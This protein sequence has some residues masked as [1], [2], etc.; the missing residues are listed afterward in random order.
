MT[1]LIRVTANKSNTTSLVDIDIIQSTN[2]ITTN[3]LPVSFIQ[4]EVVTETVLPRI[5]EAAIYAKDGTLLSDK[6]KYQFDIEA[7]SERQ[8][9]VKHRFQ[10]SAK[11]SGVY[12]NKGV[13]LVLKSPV[14][15][16]S[17]WKVYRTYPY[18]LNISFKNDFEGF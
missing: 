18:T 13:E 2:R 6:F 14:A 16:T 7:G 8:R 9:E 5:I 10:L 17:K 3:I 15:G 1:P 4:S 11:A 12:K